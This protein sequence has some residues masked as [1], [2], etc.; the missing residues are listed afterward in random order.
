V[1]EDIDKHRSEPILAA[2]A[3]PNKEYFKALVMFRKRIA[4]GVADYDTLVPAASACICA[5]TPK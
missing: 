3:N 4:C 1:F 2:L 5:G